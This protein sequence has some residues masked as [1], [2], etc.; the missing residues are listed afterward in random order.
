MGGQG[1]AR[2]KLLGHQPGGHAFQRLLHLAETRDSGQVRRIALFIAATYPESLNAAQELV[3]ESYIGA[4]RSVGEPALVALWRKAILQCM[5][6]ATLGSKNMEQKL[7]SVT[8]SEQLIRDARVAEQLQFVT[9]HIAESVPA[10]G[11]DS[12]VNVD[13]KQA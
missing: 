10:G 3:V 1:L 7:Q 13:S 12:Q 11:Q 8:L 5:K 2:S 6:T 4:A 9:E